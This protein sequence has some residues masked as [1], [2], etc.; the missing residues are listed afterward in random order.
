MFPQL[1]HIGNFFLPTY[2]LLVALGFLTGVW[3]AARLAGKA[4]LDRE[5]VLNL[6]VYTAIG[7]LLGAKLFMIAMDLD[8][9]LRNPSE[10]FS[11]STLQAGG[12]F[13]GGLI[14]ALITAFWYMRRKNLP[15]LATADAF[16]PGI[17]IGHAFGRVGCFSAGCCW[18]A[19]SHLPWAVT[20]TNT[21]AH[22][23]F[24][25]PLGIPLQPTQLYEAFAEAIIF[26][27]LYRQ[28]FRAHR[29]G[30]IIGLYLVLYP[31]VRFLVE[32]VRAHD[33]MNPH[34]GPFVLEQWLALGLVALGVWLMTRQVQQS[35]TAP[36]K[37]N[38]RLSAAR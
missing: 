22:R 32:F 7:G 11:L 28:F 4:G 2:G 30:A 3:T 35:P 27:I 14:F 18:G 20:F 9:Y 8:Y 38:S 16:A 19:E 15:G 12:I 23:L 29:P 21:E 31:S 13:F 36:R 17:A 26:V 10:I 24:G 5:S 6:G 25:V 33:D 1:F 34:F 37:G